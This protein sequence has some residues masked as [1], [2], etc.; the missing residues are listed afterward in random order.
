MD[1]H[2]EDF[3]EGMEKKFRQSSERTESLRVFRGSDGQIVRW[4]ICSFFTFCVQFMICVENLCMR[5]FRGWALACASAS[6]LLTW[7]A[8]PVR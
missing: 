7:I 1:I 8:H 2:K 4:T 6:A 3:I 5:P